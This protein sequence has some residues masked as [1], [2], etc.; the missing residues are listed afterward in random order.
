MEKPTKQR[1]VVILILFVTLV[2]A[3]LDRVNVSI[4]VADEKFLAD[5]GIK[6]DP[7]A[8]G[9][10]MSVFMAT[11]ALSQCFLSPLGDWIGPRKAMTLAVLFWIGSCFFGGLVSAFAGML[12]VRVILGMGEGMHWPMQ[13]KIVKNW[14]PPHER[15]RANSVWLVGLTAGT[16]IA[17]P[18]LVWVIGNWGWRS[19]FFTLAAIGFLPLILVWFFITDYPRQSKRV[20]QQELA[21]IESG[22][23]AEEEK[24]A[25][26][27]TTAQGVALWQNWKGFLFNV[28]Y[29]LCVIFYIFSS[30]VFFGLLTWIPSFLKQAM[31]FSW[32]S[33]GYWANAPYA[34]SMIGGLVAGW[35]T[36]KIPRKATL[37]IFHMLGA[38]I[39]V[40]GAAHSTGQIEAALWLILA[41]TSLMIG[42]PGHW[43]MIQKIVPPAALGAG[44]GLESALG[45]LAGAVTPMIIGYFIKATGGYTGGLMVMSVFALIGMLAMIALWVRKV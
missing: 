45:S 34:V 33:M 35:L 40:Y 3:Y 38:A 22:L 26:Q 21:Y 12:A 7:V 4:L 10:L 14:F 24:L 20:N 44:A 8:M 5:M 23:K 25:Q 28:D 9:A 43:A 16:A 29:W 13:M 15:A 19:S 32:K 11:Y 31:G 2:V 6:G 42:L 36:D 30:A 17:M 37:G 39:G 18:F 41:V 1:I 27:R